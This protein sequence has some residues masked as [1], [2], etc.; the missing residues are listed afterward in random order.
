M[1]LKAALEQRFGA[2]RLQEIQNP[3]HPE[4][5]LYQL[6][7]ELNVPITVIMTSSLSNYEM[8]VS[9]KWKGREFNELFV[10]LPS[11]WDLNDLQNINSNWVYEWLF[12]LERFVLEKQSWFGPGHTIP[13]GNPPVTI[14][15]LLKQEYFIFLDPIF[16]ESEMKPMTVAGKNIHFLAIVPIFGDEL[17]YKMGKGTQKF[18][19]K[20]IQRKNDERI[21]EYRKSILSSRMIFF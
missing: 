13:C 9:E 3:L 6:Y 10:C 20:F 18:I 15:H 21:E 12:K 11:Y 16:L 8:P 17:D 4:Q 5:T 19:R 2:H 1:S 7:L 14:S